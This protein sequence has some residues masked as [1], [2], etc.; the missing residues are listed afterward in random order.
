VARLQLSFPSQVCCTL[1]IL[2]VTIQLTNCGGSASPATQGA[3]SSSGTSA[4]SGPASSGSG[5]GGS[6]TGPGSGSSSAPGGFAGGTGASGQSSAAQFLYAAPVPN[7]GPISTRINQQNGTLASIRN[8]PATPGINPMMLAIDPTGT[9]LYE[10]SENGIWAYTLNRQSGE[11]TLITGSPYEGSQPLVAITVDQ[12]GKFVY[13][14]GNTGV[15]GY[16]IQAGG[17]LKGIAGSPFPTAAP[18][19]Q[20]GPSNNL[21]IDQSDKFLYVT[22][23][24]GIFAFTIDSNT[25]RLAAIGGSPFK[26]GN[27]PLS[28]VITPSNKF[29]YESNLN[30]PTTY[31]Y[32]IDQNT[33]VLAEISGSPFKTR[34]G[35]APLADNMTIAVAGKFLY[36]ANRGTFSVD[37]NTGALARVSSFLPGDWPVISPTGNFL[38]AITTDQNCWHCD[39]GV[40]AYTVDPNS[41]NLTLVPNS[42]FIMNNSFAGAVVSLAVT[43]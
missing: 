14:T 38:W 17:Q 16:S 9:Y 15:W 13:A 22:A 2:V 21:A 33:G 27:A 8:P 12:S 30:D 7:G 34:D 31:G 23:S 35:V 32:S 40:S 18:S 43:K 3:P 36:I 5:S 25:G 41:G 11:L 4:S 37:A 6:G 24:P 10:T 19:N 29:L 1:A 28:L 26:A 39:I 42:F 20:F